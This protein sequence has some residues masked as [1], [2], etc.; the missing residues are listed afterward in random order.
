MYPGDDT[1]QDV[2][3]N[4]VDNIYHII[5]LLSDHL[6]TDC[7]RYLH[8]ALCHYTLPICAGSSDYI[9]QKNLCREDCEKLELEVCQLVY[10][11]V[12]TT[13]GQVQRKISLPD[14][15][16]LPMQ[17]DGADCVNIFPQDELYKGR[18]VTKYF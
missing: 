10:E 15:H 6:N 13:T 7:S 16:Y 11:T 18:P 17:T 14:C 8:S 1:I 2:E 5:G 4:L 3:K 9:T 12:A